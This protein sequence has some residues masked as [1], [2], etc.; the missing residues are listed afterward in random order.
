MSEQGR[1]I[2]AAAVRAMTAA[3]EKGDLLSIALPR[4]TAKLDGAASARAG[5][6]ATE[7]LRWANRSDRVLGPH[8]RLR[9]ED[10]VM[11]AL[12][13][14]IYELFEAGE[15]HH[16]VVNDIVSLVTRS[17]AGLVNGV[18]RNV[19]RRQV[20]WASLPAPQVPK[21]LRKRLLTAWGKEAVLAMERV[22]AQRPPLDLSLREAGEATHWAK[23]LGGRIL[24]GGSLRLDS[25]A[26]VSDLP[27]FG[28]G[29]WWVQDAG[30]AVA[31]RV[32]DAQPEEQVLDLCAAPGG[33]TMQLAATGATVTALDSSEGRM[34]RLRENLSRTG[35]Q[36]RIVV[37]NALE[38]QPDRTFDAILL[39]APCSATGTL[40]RHPEL[41]YARDGSGIEDLVRLQAALL[42]RASAWVRPG[43]RL[44]YCTCSLLPEEGE[45]QIDA[46]L[47]RNAG[48]AIA[49]PSFDDERWCVAQGL[50][51]RPD[52]WEDAGGIDGFFVA[53]LENR[54]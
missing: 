18:L 47:A 31:A 32:L 4:V 25:G 11:N 53:R 8:L 28:E 42:D 13:L 15:A 41:A 7:A 45:W 48:F 12:R 50:R 26:Q 37:A 20:D 2:R 40:R 27:G 30:A 17:K 1:E 3:T 44:V 46:F 39:D 35:L 34:V 49:E 33:K 22:Q 19:L 51:L 24:P 52:H 43:G 14:A 36:A 23:A 21:W 29:A 10:S 9:P 16:G 6:L 5:R 38:W 54:S